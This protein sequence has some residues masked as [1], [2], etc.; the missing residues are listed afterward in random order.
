MVGVLETLSDVE[1]PRDALTDAQVRR[2]RSAAFVLGSRGRR[3]A[4]HSSGRY[5]G[6]R[7]NP[8]GEMSAELAEAAATVA[9]GVAERPE[10]APA[11][12]EQLAA[13]AEQA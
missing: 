10:L 4:P 9:A 1:I 5:G 3:L 11:V 13:A 6:Q 2:A 12:F 8:E 7:P